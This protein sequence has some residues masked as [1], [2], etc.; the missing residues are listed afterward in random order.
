[1]FVDC[2]TVLRMESTITKFEYFL[3]PE[4]NSCSRTTNDKCLK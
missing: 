1:M 3:L 2:L 4:G